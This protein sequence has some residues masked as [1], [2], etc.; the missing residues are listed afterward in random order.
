VNSARTVIN[1]IVKQ[2]YGPS[3]DFLG[4]TAWVIRPSSCAKIAVTI[5][6]TLITSCCPVS[7]KK[8][9]TREIASRE[10]RGFGDGCEII[11]AFAKFLMRG[12]FEHC[13]ESASFRCFR[14]TAS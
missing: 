7:E 3:K 9:G 5:I 4:M 10:K 6:K 11:S 13:R 8:L 14:W 2:L 1:F 12:L